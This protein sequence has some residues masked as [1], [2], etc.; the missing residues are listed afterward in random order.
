MQKFDKNNDGRIELS[1]VRNCIV[2]KW[3]LLPVNVTRSD[4]ESPLKI[5]DIWTQLDCFK[6][7]KMRAFQCHNCHLDSRNINSHVIHVS[8]G[9]DSA[10]RG[11]LPA[12]LQTVF[13]LQLWVYGGKFTEMVNLTFFCIPLNLNLLNC[14]NGKW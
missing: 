3:S 1:E 4:K 8:A 5:A 7:S 11:E 2:Q 10:N 14:Y 12:L 9:P 13:G 6:C